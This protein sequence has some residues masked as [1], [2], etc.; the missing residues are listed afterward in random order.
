IAGWLERIELAEVS[1]ERAH[2]LRI[3]IV[4]G[5]AQDDIVEPRLP[6]LRDGRRIERCGQIDA[7][8]LGAER[9]TQSADSQTTHGQAILPF[10]SARGN[11]PLAGSRTRLGKFE[12]H[13]LLK[14]IEGASV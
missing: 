11:E 1:A 3:K 4:A 10:R 8:Y 7:G 5:K 6:D 12:R 2:L 13:L 9:I 14:G